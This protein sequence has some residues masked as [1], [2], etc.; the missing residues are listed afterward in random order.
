MAARN[1]IATLTELFPGCFFVRRRKPLKVGIHDEVL[2]AL[3]A[4]TAKQVGLALTIYTSNSG[5]LHCIREGA[6]RVGLG[7]EVTGYVTAEEAENAKQRPQRTQ[8]PIAKQAKPVSGTRRSAQAIRPTA[9]RLGLADL[10]AAARSRRA[11]G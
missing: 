2:A 11:A 9:P 10:K 5:Y 8:Q 7:G 1:T 3:P 4:A 6:P